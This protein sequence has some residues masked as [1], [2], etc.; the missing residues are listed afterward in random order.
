MM[1]TKLILIAAGA[2]ASLACSGGDPVNIG[3]NN[4]V[5]TGELLSDYAATWDGYVETYQFQSGSDRVRLTLDENG[6]GLLEV[7]DVPL[8]PAPTDPHV[9]YASAGEDPNWI[10]PFWIHEGF[11]YSVTDATVENSRMQLAVHNDEVFNA[12]C[13]LQTSF[14]GSE[15]GS[16]S[17]L[18]AGNYGKTGDECSYVTPADTQVSVDCGKVV[19]CMQVCECDATGCTAPGTVETLL[20]GSLADDGETLVGTLLIKSLTDGVDTERLTVRLERQ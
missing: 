7:G 13:E 11:R 15:P 19:L 4:P 3:E 10:A 20:D 9:G 1:Q 5:K 2:L 14:P 8:L 17:C 18:P 16:Y 12:W 6:V